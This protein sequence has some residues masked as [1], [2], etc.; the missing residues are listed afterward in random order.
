MQKYGVWALRL[1]FFDI[2]IE[3][4]RSNPNRKITNIQ[5]RV[6]EWGE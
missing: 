5:K 3:K 6:K 2:N 1:L 4:N